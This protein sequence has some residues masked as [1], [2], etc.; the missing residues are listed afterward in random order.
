MQLPALI[1]RLAD[2]ADMP[3]FARLHHVGEDFNGRDRTGERLSLNAIRSARSLTQFAD[4]QVLNLRL[5]EIVRVNPGVGAEEVL[6]ESRKI[7]LPD[8]GFSALLAARLS[9]E[10]MTADLEADDRRALMR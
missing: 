10:V 1:A 9:A 7:R 6:D 2:N 3:E 5:S 4:A 8:R